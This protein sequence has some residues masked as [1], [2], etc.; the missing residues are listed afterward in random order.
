MHT[1]TSELL[2]KKIT[3]GA[4]KFEEY[5][6][7]VF[8]RKSTLRRKLKEDDEPAFIMRQLDG[9]KTDVPFIDLQDIRKYRKSK[10]GML[11]TVISNFNMEFAGMAS[12]EFDTIKEYTALDYSRKV[13]R[14][15]QK[16][17]QEMLS[18][19]SIKI[20]DQIGDEYSDRFCHDVAEKLL[21]QNKQDAMDRLAYYKKLAA[22]EY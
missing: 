3:F 1:F 22:L 13:Q 2:R 10:V 7:Y 6:K 12:I 14:E 19:Q 20:V 4:K 21:A 5:P 16:A 15:N 11:A 8:S 18:E 9:K 17:I